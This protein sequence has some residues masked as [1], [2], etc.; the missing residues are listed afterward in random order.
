MYFCL[1]VSYIASQLALLLLIQQV[2][3]YGTSTVEV[4][5]NIGECRQLFK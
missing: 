2:R 1:L 4:Y 5:Y 3:C